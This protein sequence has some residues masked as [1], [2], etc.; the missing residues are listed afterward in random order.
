MYK[1]GDKVIV[2]YEDWLRFHKEYRNKVF[3]IIAFEGFGMNFLGTETTTKYRVR[4]GDFSVS[5]TISKSFNPFKKL[6]TL[7]SEY[8]E[9]L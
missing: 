5:A 6:S 3:E 2:V 4:C 7:L 9:K 1:V 8:L